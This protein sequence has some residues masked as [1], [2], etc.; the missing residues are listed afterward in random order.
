MYQLKK[1]DWCL[2]LL[3]NKLACYSI[4]LSFTIIC[5]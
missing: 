1:K 4:N 5:S 3:K 2:V